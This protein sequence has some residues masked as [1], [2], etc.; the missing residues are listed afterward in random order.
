MKKFAALFATVLVMALSATSVFAAVSP[1]IEGAKTDYADGTVTS[2]TAGVTGVTAYSV[3]DTAATDSAVAS[4]KA[5]VTTAASNAN[6]AN[7]EVLTEITVSGVTPSEATPVTIDIPVAGITASSN[8]IVLNYHDGAWQTN[9]VKSVAAGDGKVTV[10]FTHLSPV[11]VITYTEAA[12]PAPQPQAPSYNYDD[13]PVSPKTGVLPVAA[14][15][16][17]ICLAGA[18]V[19]GKKVKFN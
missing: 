3:V 16:A 1:S 4:A 12:A 18:A 17:G 6:S 2:T 13:E 7:I 14:I 19:C 15:A 9:S 10:T 5:A 8:V 11:M